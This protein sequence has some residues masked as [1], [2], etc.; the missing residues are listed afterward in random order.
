MK[1]FLKLFAWIVGIIAALIAVA[2]IYI[3]LI[4]DPNKY[5]TE[6]TT[7]VH[8]AT[9]RELSIQGDLKL[10]LFP[11]LGVETGAMS[12]SNLPAFGQ[13]PFAKINDSV[14]RVK[15]IP[16]LKKDIEVDTVILHGLYLN[17][18]RNPSGQGNWEDLTT[19]SG[20]KTQ[21]AQSGTNTTAPALA[22]FAIGGIQ[23]KQ[24]TVIWDDRQNGTHYELNGLSLN[25]GPISPKAPITVALA[26]QI[27]STKPDLTAHLDLS[28]RA[29]FD[30]DTQRLQLSGLKL[31]VTTQ[32][33]VLPADKSKFTLTTDA[34][35]KLSENQYRLNKLR[36][37]ASLHLRRQTPFQER[38]SQYHNHLVECLSLQAHHRASLPQ[39]QQPHSY[40]IQCHP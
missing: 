4:F 39:G 16:L 18:I 37:L 20:K 11:W 26:T 15:L 9:G 19:Q 17:L 36:L 25:T 13:T 32:S 3:L 8:N 6:I 12:L 1:R 2:V 27:K 28:T 22:A 30:I 7:A 35:L 5:K 38:F 24:A 34:T 14:I 33:K 31:T 23:L 10:S 29:L 40:Y 21:A